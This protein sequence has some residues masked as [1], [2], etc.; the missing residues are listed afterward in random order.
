MSDIGLDVTEQPQMDLFSPPPN[1]NLVLRS[2][3]GVEFRVHAVLLGLC[4]SVFQGMFSTGTRDETIDLGEDSEALSLM[5][6]CIYPNEMPTLHSLRE[7]KIGF[8]V[9][10]K[11]DMLGV[12]RALDQQLCLILKNGTGSERFDPLL[13]CD[14]AN[15]YGLRETGQVA[16]RLVTID[17][18]DLRNP[19]KLIDLAVKHPSSSTL[20]G[21]IG[22][23]SA[24][25]KIL[26]RVLLNFHAHPMRWKISSKPRYYIMCDDCRER[27]EDDGLSHSPPAWLI[28]WGS[29]AYQ[30]LLSNSP[31]QAPELFDT[32]ILERL[33]ERYP[34]AVCSNCVAEIQG[35]S[36]FRAKFYEW[37]DGMREYLNKH[38]ESL[39]ALYA[40]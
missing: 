33:E 29:H 3:D 4:S 5:L 18:C 38:L 2:N 21:L 19:A 40:L 22:I 39:E 36:L 10:Q 26:T 35:D 16:A 20:I 34:N 1:G 14:L 28:S 37:A 32:R 6:R 11:Y 24:R 31:D 25:T 30:R 27:S 13:V 23:Q 8:E 15:S 9:A 7:F 17:K 12:T